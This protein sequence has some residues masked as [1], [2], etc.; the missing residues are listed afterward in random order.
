MKVAIIGATGVV[1][2]EIIS[3]LEDSAVQDIEVGMFASPKS[4]G[5]VVEFRKD[6]YTVGAFSLEALKAFDYA[7]MSAGGDFSRKYAK[8]IADQGTI[9]ID[10]SSAWRMDP[11]LPLVVPE[12][13]GHVLEERQLSIIANPNCSTIQM[14]VNLA[15]LEKAF[16]LAM[17]H[18]STYQSVS[19]TGQKGLNELATQ[20][21]QQF[22]MEEITPE[23]YPQ[24]IA[25]NVLPAIGPVDDAGHAEEE[26]KMVRETKKILENDSIEVLATTVRVPVFS[27]HSESIVVKLKIAVSRDEVISVLKTQA[28]LQVFESDLQEEYP[29]PLNVA[30]KQET[31]V[32]RVRL[33]YGKDASGK[34]EWVQMWN[35]ADNLKKGAATNAVQI[36]ETISN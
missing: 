12:V 8:G 3:E 11:E 31:Y 34:S 24:P 21:K 28:G 29:T 27:C 5:Q 9:V 20:V 16:G 17:V 10:N 14:M 33:P 6:S 23:V 22:N 36:L 25:F 2:R 30:G 26:V 7:L 4:E 35:V 1:G 13:N 15:P 32:T 19:G 18:V